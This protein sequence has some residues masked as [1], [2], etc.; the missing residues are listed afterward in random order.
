[1][2]AQEDA[3]AL[4]ALYTTGHW[5]IN[6]SRQNDAIRVFHA[7]IVCAPTDE[8]GW[9]ALG[10]CHEE[11][12]HLEV[13]YSLYEAGR[14]AAAPSTRCEIARAR[15]A[16]RLGEREHA[17]DAYACAI[18]LADDAGDNELLDLASRERNQL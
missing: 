17:L 18:D 14:N 13:A 11:L 16:K 6:Q 8:R 10:F 1:M 12:D 2:P 9:L 3:A 15:V 5:L 4:D 7:M